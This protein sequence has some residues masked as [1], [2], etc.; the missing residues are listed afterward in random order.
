MGRRGRPA[1]NAGIDRR[2]RA[3]QLAVDVRRIDPGTTVEVD[4]VTYYH[5][6]LAR[7][8]VLLADGLPA[9]S[10]LETG[11]RHAFENAPGAIQMHPDFEPDPRRVAM[12]WERFGYAPLLGDGSQLR[13]V[14]AQLASQAALLGLATAA[15]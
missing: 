3:E 13:R 12:V 15:A 11:G 10:Y 6:E 5:V 1:D 8:D 2:Q 14:Q 7:H 4:T 9:E